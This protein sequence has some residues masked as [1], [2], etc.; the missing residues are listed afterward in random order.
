ML[1]DSV[2]G[3]ISHTLSNDNGFKAKYGQSII[4]PLPKSAAYK[5]VLIMGIG[6][7]KEITD[8]NFHGLLLTEANLSNVNFS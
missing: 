5:R 4:V 3:H 8:Q 7:V 6:D 1:D 2:K